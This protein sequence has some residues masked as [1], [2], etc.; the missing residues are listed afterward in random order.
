[1]SASPE[2][3]SMEFAN[4]VEADT[5]PEHYLV[6][7]GKS[8][9]LG[10]FTA[11]MSQVLRRGD[12][13]V[14]DS[15]R[16]REVGTIL[17]AASVRQS[18]MLGAIATGS[19][20]RPLAAGDATALT[21]LRATEQRL[22]E[23][24]RELARAQSLPVEVLDVDVLFDERAILQYVGPQETPLDEF[25]R[26][27]SQAFHLD[28]RLENLALPKESAELH[29]HGCGKPDCGKTAGG[30]CSTCST[31]GG[32]SSCGTGATNLRPYFA[33][34]RTQMEVKNRTS[35]V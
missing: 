20:V 8:G 5:P 2:H 34:L 22:F 3:G 28:I 17:C 4:A 31:G 14:I 33:H 26:T 10:S 11:H 7:H 9:G 6:S 16:G 13:V 27:L 35:L 23:A 25:A 12:R 1:M 19:I 24:G 29:D 15:P 30:G 18:R 21:E 32:C